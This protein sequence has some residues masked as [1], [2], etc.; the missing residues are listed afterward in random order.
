MLGINYSL[1]GGGYGVRQSKGAQGIGVDCSGLTSYVYGTLGIKLP[2]HSTT[3]YGS[4]YKTSIANAQPGDLV[5][6]PKGGHVGIYIGNGKILHSP[7]P[8]Q[9]VQIR[10]IF[11]GENIFA[12]HIQLPGE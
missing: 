3:Q 11:K 8:G 12:I 6:W 10:D 4:G 2:R 9:K 1:G 5:G 7:R